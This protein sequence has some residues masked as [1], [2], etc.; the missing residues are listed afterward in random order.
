MP[1]SVYA[2]RTLDLQP[3]TLPRDDRGEKSGL[4]PYRAARDFFNSLLLQIVQRKG[5]AKYCGLCLARIPQHDLLRC[6]RLNRQ[7]VLTSAHLS[8][9]FT[10][11][12]ADVGLRGV[13][14]ESSTPDAPS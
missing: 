3:L 13:R 8:S 12:V 6:Q 14:P 11:W 2:P 10:Y 4:T 9:L 7:G 1:A 5:L